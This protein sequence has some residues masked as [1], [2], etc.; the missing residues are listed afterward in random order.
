MLETKKQ[1]VKVESYAIP[2]FRVQ[3]ATPSRGTRE[4]VIFQKETQK[5]LKFTK[6]HL[7]HI[8]IK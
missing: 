8:F 4:S 5:E 3:E 7:R 2:L 1:R 6:L